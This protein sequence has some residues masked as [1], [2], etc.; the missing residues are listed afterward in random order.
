MTYLTESQGRWVGPGDRIVHRKRLGR[1][2]VL[3]L[4]DAD[5]MDDR[6][7]LAD[8]AHSLNPR[9][10]AAD[11]PAQ[12]VH[13]LG[14]APVAADRRWMREAQDVRSGIRWAVVAG[15]IWAVMGALLLR[16]GKGHS[17]PGTKGEDGEQ[18]DNKSGESQI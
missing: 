17:A 18:D 15:I 13:W 7:W 9:F 1:G 2:E 16:T 6:L 12:L 4:G 14:G 3:L 10:W 5:P 8:P 11:T